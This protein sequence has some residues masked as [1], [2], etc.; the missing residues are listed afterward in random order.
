MFSTSIPAKNVVYNIT[1][2]ASARSADPH[3]RKLWSSLKDVCKL[4]GIAFGAS[5]EH[6]PVQFQHMAVQTGQR[7]YTMGQPFDM[8][9]VVR[10]GFLKTVV[11]DDGGSEQILNFPMKGNLLGIDGLHNKRYPS[12]AVAL[13]TC[14]I[15]C[16][17]FK[18]LA[19]LG[20]QHPGLETAIYSILSQEL[21][22]E[23]SMLN[24]IS[25]LSAEA[26]VARFLVW[27]SNR[28]MKMGYSGTQFNLRMT[29]QEIG[30]YL[31]LTLETVSRALSGFKQ[32]GLI[33]VNQRAI[34]IK[35]LYALQ[36]LR[37]L[38][39][40]YGNPRRAVTKTLAR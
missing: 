8:L 32:M 26:R 33:E 31:G 24:T 13:S 14:D 28:Y 30:S 10:S 4:L 12:E 16:V 25:S 35:D 7:V 18:Q 15:V 23:H 40:A 11:I 17:P 27:L 36:T 19:A 38:P 3:A 29:R 39:P 5:V 22:H 9:Y 6:E 34:E 2:P 21:M 20:Q 1:P 37:R